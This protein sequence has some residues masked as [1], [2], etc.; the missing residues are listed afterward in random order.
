[1][2]GVLGVLAARGAK[3]LVTIGNVGNVY[4]YVSGSM[5]SISPTTYQDHGG[6]S[7]T[8]TAISATDNGDATWTLVFRLDG[9]PA[10]SD[11]TFADFHVGGVRYTRTSSA[12]VD[13]G[14]G[15]RQWAWAGLGS[16]PIG[17]SGTAY[18]RIR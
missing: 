12:S 4:G 5:G 11:T 7:R 3:W 9:T 2:S 14:G 17:T 10:D 16:N 6:T 8:I 13:L 1:M 18:A 15:V